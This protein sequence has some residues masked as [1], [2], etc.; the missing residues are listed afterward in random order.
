[1]K[2]FFITTIL[3]CCLFSCA[4]SQ[5]A[6]RPKNSKTMST[7]KN[8]YDFEL[9]S[10]D[11]KSTIKFSDFKGKKVMLINV[12]SKCGLTPQYEELQ[13]L[14]EKMNGKVV[15]IGIPANNFMGQE[16]GTNEE[17]ATFCKKNYGVT[18]QMA[19]KISVIGSDQHALYQW[20]SKKDQNGWNEQEPTWNFA[21]YLI[22]ENG[23]L[24]KYFAPKTSVLSEEVTKAL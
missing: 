24:E 20:L 5:D 7:T 8:L 13:K 10:L 9:K 2:L 22:D 15:F 12:A 3:V 4:S 1:M 6:S 17:I 14:H 19:E 18:F 21:K 23:N 11:N 16:P